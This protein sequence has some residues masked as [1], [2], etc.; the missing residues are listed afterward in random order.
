VQQRCSLRVLQDGFALER[1]RPLVLDIIRI[2][3]YISR[4]C[5]IRR[6]WKIRL[7]GRPAPARL[8]A[9]RLSTK[10]LVAQRETVCASNGVGTSIQTAIWRRATDSSG[11]ARTAVYRL[12]EGK[13]GS[14][15]LQSPA[16]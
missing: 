3:E 7:I 6:M 16:N 12:R 10:S 11:V 13:L 15:Q 1:Q 14:R 2:T 5:L 8:R 4:I 9:Y